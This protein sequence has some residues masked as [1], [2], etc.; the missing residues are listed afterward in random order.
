VAG[1]PGLV[2]ETF[3]DDATPLSSRQVVHLSSDPAHAGGEVQAASTRALLLWDAGDGVHAAFKNGGSI[4]ADQLIAGGTAAGLQMHGS[5]LADGKVVLT[6]LQNDGGAQDAWAAVVDPATNT[7]QRQELGASSGGIVVA[8]GAHGAFAVSWRNGGEIDARGFD[9][10]GYFGDAIAVPGD[11]AGVDASGDVVVSWSDGSGQ[12]SQLYGLQID[13]FNLYAGQI[14]TLPSGGGTA[15]GTPYADTITGGDNGTNYIRGMDGAD[16]I[17]GGL[18][19]NEINGN[20]GADTIYGRSQVGDFLLGGQGNDLIDITQSAGHNDINGNRGSDTLLGSDGGDTLRGGRGDDVLRGGAG[21]DWLSGDLGN[22]T[23]TGGGG[24]DSF[25]MVVG[26]GTD[27]VTDFTQ[28]QG[29]RVVLDA[30]T[31]WTAA[32]SGADVVVSLAG[33]GQLILQNTQL[34]SLTSGWIVVG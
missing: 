28:S 14:I 2:Q 17:T 4:G 26:G 23:M 31:G 20:Q 32:Q 24:A 25:H 12:H 1:Q 7:A 11:V 27:V 16:R 3:D 29:D 6:W 30:G 19:H 10:H 8:P 33:G 13:P 9:G 15:D 34:D 21:A 18:G 5:F 22:D